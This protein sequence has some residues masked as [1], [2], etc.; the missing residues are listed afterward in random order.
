MSSQGRRMAL[1]PAAVASWEAA[2]LTSSQALLRAAVWLAGPPANGRPLCPSGGRA[3][4]FP[5]V[6][7]GL[8]PSPLHS[9]PV[10][11][12]IESKTLTPLPPFKIIVC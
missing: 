9:I 11:F 2:A 6:M 3:E 1:Q 5:N 8:A 7:Y 12:L 10:A 4:A